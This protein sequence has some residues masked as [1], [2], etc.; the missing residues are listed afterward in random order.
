LIE[1]FELYPYGHDPQE[2][3]IRLLTNYP[4]PFNPTTTIGFVISNG[5][6]QN[7]ELQIFNS[8]GQ[9]LRRYYNLKGQGSVIWNGKDNDD[10]FV[11]SG[12]YL[13]RL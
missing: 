11:S 4:N 10:K 8:R 12:I 3:P 2:N 1:N 13:Y 5:S 7:I 9:I 6:Q